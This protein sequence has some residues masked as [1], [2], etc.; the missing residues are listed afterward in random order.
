MKK[1]LL[2]T[3]S[4]LFAF[5]NLFCLQNY[6]AKLGVSLSSIIGEK[7]PKSEFKTNFSFGFYTTF[8][9]NIWLQL[10]PEMLLSAKGT[11]YHCTEKFLIDEDLDGEFNE[12]P[13]DF[14]DNNHDGHID[15]DTPELPFDVDGY[16]QTYYLDL[17]VL[18]KANIPQIYPKKISVL[19]GPS[20][21]ILL[22]GKYKLKHNDKTYT[23]DLSDL[24]SIDLAA[25]LGMEYSFKKFQLEFRVAQSVLENN[26]RSG[27]KN[28]VEEYP[29][30]Y[31]YEEEH[32]RYDKIYGY[33]TQY[34]LFL[35]KQF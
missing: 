33:H 16:F 15:E 11:N 6:G 27:C 35:R 26:Y 20:F 32:L 28:L 4:L 31:D 19:F 24:H 34:T 29:N 7:M 1:T 23:G 2:I 17:P 5:T 22:S 10:Q 13:F 25:V 8:P 21:N 9:L 14:L 30:I 3:V 12:D 18:L